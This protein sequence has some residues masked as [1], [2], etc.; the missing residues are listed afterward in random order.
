M[1]T[2]YSVPIETLRRIARERPQARIGSI[3][4]HLDIEALATAVRA[5]MKPRIRVKAG[6]SVASQQIHEP[7]D[8]DDCECEDWSLSPVDRICPTCDRHFPGEGS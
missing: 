8:H 7:E 4:A 5:A 2:P 6:R 3:V 1:S